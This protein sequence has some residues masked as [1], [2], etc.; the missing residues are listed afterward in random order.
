MPNKR[1]RGNNLIRNLLNG[2]AIKLFDEGIAEA[3][4]QNILDCAAFL[5]ERSL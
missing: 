4:R 1:R 3:E 5:N 2:K